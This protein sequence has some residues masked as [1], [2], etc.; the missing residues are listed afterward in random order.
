VS[1]DFA[2]SASRVPKLPLPLPDDVDLGYYKA[3]NYI[4]DYSPT[5]TYFT[6]PEFERWLR[7]Y[8]RWQLFGR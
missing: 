1:P 8:W 4:G 3:A 2:G 7:Y 6:G 5:G